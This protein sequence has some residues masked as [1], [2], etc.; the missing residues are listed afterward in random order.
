MTARDQRTWD[1]SAQMVRALPWNIPSPSGSRSSPPTT[2]GPRMRPTPADSSASSRRCSPLS[3]SRSSTRPSHNGTRSSK[4][5]CRN[6][7]FQLSTSFQ[8]KHNKISNYSKA[9][10]IQIKFNFKIKTC[11]ITKFSSEERKCDALPRY[12]N[13]AMLFHQD[14]IEDELADSKE[15]IKDGGMTLDDDFSPFSG[16]AELSSYHT[17]CLL[18]PL[19]S[20]IIQYEI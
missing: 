18:K 14:K 2:C 20:F 8:T 19:F 7:L 11:L 3:T 13:I 1:K 17:T 6:Q 10:R 5:K 4:V 16:R 15:N 9:K 12:N